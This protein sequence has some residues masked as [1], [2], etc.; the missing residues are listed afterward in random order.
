MVKEEISYYLQKGFCLK[1]FFIK[2]YKI[3]N[4]GFYYIFDDMSYYCLCKMWF[5]W[6]YFVKNCLFKYDFNM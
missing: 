4:R 5:N 1:Y 2:F 6:F 3:F